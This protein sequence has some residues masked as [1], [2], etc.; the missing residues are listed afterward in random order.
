MQF[1]S[2]CIDIS[3]LFFHVVV[4]TLASFFSSFCENDKKQSTVFFFFPLR[5]M[6][7]SFYSFHSLELLRHRSV[8]GG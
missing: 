6:T 2:L 5:R 4:C 8:N 7:L 1:R 3:L